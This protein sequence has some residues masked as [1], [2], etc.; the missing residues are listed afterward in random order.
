MP[1][2]PDPDPRSYREA[3]R[4]TDPAKSHARSLRRDLTPPERLLWPKIKRNQV[5]GLR[6]RKQ[7]PMGPFIADFYCHEVRLV[8][9]IDG[10]THA[11]ER[12]LHDARRDEWMR[13]RG[14]RVLRIPAAEV[15]NNLHGVLI[16]ISRFA[17][18]PEQD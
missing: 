14:V 18:G 13:A 12:R 16:T 17:E 1:Q 15:F 6:F 9:E 7:H 3:L 4:A 8:V 11:G 2:T 5:K 10:P